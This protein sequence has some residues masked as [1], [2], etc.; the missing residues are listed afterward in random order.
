MQVHDNYLAT[1]DKRKLITI[2]WLQ[3]RNL[4]ALFFFS[5]DSELIKTVIN[6]CMQ[7]TGILQPICD[8]KEDID[9]TK[10]FEQMDAMDWGEKVYGCIFILYILVFRLNN[11]FLYCYLLLSCFFFCCRESLPLVGKMDWFIFGYSAIQETP[12]LHTL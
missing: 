12:V 9:P 10:L 8:N 1:I 6:G 11:C 5:G 3:V 7:T 4:L 2:Q